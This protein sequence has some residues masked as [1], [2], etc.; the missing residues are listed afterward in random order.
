MWF[1]RA[2]SFRI[3]LAVAIPTGAFLIVSGLAITD[4]L[5][6]DG[7]MRQL[8]EQVSFATAAGAIIH[9]LQKERGA[10][11]LYLGSKG[12]QFG[13][14]LE[15]QR[16]LTDTRLAA[17]IDQADRLRAAT[18][19]SASTMREALAD[20]AETRRKISTLALK[21]QESFAYFTQTI[22][23]T[24]DQ[25][26]GLGKAD[27]GDLA[28]EIQAYLAFIEGKEWAGQE[29]ATGSGGFAAGRFDPPLLQ[30]L[31]GL[32]Y[33]QNTAFL[34]FK[35]RTDPTMADA[36]TGLEAALRPDVDRLRQIAYQPGA[37][38][39]PALAP[40]WFKATTERIN[41]MKGLEDRLAQDMLART[42]ALQAEAIA[43]LKTMLLRTSA[44]IVIVLLVG[45]L[46]ARRISRPIVGMTEAM[47]RLRKGDLSLAIPYA[48]RR[49]EI[50][51]MARAL[52]IFQES[53]QTNARHQAEQAA[54]ADQR[55]QQRQRLETLSATFSDGVDS[56]IAAVEDLNTAMIEAANAMVVGAH[57]TKERSQDAEVS[58]LAM[59]DR[60][61]R[62]SSACA[63]LSTS[64]QDILAQMTRSVSLSDAAARTAVETSDHAGRLFGSLEAAQTFVQL[65]HT[66]AT[67]TNLL[68]LNAAI[69]AARAGQTGKGFAIV[70]AEVKTLALQ[71]GQ[72]AEQII[73]MFDGIR[74]MTGET[75]DAVD[76]IRAMTTELS[77]V[78]SH[79]LAAV[80]QQSAATEEITRHVADVSGET[81][82]VSDVAR[83][84]HGSAHDTQTRAEGVVVT[85]GEVSLTFSGLKTRVSD[86]VT[87]L[88]S[89]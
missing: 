31:V 60:I 68:A 63:E 27:H 61:T 2:L 28:A 58:V 79:I 59:N 39:D 8:K 9:E 40:V 20:L 53:M 33:S 57:E 46:I 82:R 25:V 34:T 71:T 37:V 18:G 29:R 13:P 35:A 64:I 11:S 4:K 84:T 77:A 76:Q 72:A 65:I 81:L 47:T 51:R 17:V 10:S 23:L 67:R 49:D 54:T 16:T 24:L 44:A 66:I 52:A 26:Y 73:K 75:V 38:I 87:R 3:Y 30:R 80:A 89:A 55:E 48:D 62:I 41:A 14:E 15:T 83:T 5:A 7:Q 69:E 74:A 43:A 50:G 45:T 22:R 70:A 88:R 32:A 56:L 21:P 78:S 42:D 12:Q 36:L 19:E 6:V 1:L 86:F 85:C